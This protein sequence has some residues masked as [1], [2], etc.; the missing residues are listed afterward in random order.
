MSR[1][2]V[3]RLKVEKVHDLSEVSGGRW[4]LKE[5]RRQHIVIMVSLPS[6]LSVA[7]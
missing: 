2:M 1:L 6:M 3:K 5:E 4:W 7:S